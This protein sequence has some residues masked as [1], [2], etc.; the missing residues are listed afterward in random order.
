MYV[1]VYYETDFGPDEQYVLRIVGPFD[2][3][4]KA[5][6]KRREA[7]KYVYKAEVYNL[8]GN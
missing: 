5:E 2:D 4:E 7:D 3:F 8:E 6:A 1:V